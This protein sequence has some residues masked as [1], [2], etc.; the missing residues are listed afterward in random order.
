MTVGRAT[1]AHSTLLPPAV[2]ALRAMAPVS[3]VV[4]AAAAVGAVLLLAIGVNPVDG[5]RDLILGAVG[6]RYHRSETVVRAIPIA[7]VALGVVPALRARVFTIG[8]EGQLVVGA[9]ASTAAILTIEESPAPLLLAVGGLAGALGGA[10]WA[11]LPALLR[12]YAQVNEILSTLM[13]NYVAGFG[14][15]WVLRNTMSGPYAS[16]S[17]SSEE[18]PESAR[19]PLLLPDTR[20]HWGAIV[21]LVGALAVAWWVRSPRGFAFDVLGTHPALAARMGVRPARAVLSTMLVGG[22]AAGLAGW[23]LVAGVQGR[24]YPSVAGGLGF[25]GLVVALLGGLRPAGVL[26][27]ALLFGILATGAEGLQIGVG[28]PASLATVLQALLLGGVALSAGIRHR[29]LGQREV[30]A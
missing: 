18:L 5:Y 19:I 2:R 6:D 24:L 22:A 14:L 8:S 20:L 3:M 29:R 10:L 30:P 9:L 11:L 4:G 27:V 21:A 26:G 15:L 7:V 25:T 23:M 1:W 12:G 16:V 17:P 13:L 28:V